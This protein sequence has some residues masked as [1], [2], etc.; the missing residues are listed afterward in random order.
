MDTKERCLPY[1][2]LWKAL[3]ERAAGTARKGKAILAGAPEDKLA[4]PWCLL[5]EQAV[6]ILLNTCP[7]VARSCDLLDAQQPL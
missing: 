5:Q 1:L 4:K 6:C 2:R 7:S 3:Q